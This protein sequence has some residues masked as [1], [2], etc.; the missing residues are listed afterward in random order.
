VASSTGIS[1][2][3]GASDRFKFQREKPPDPNTKKSSFRSY[4]SAYFVS[5]T[6][7]ILLPY[8]KQVL[9]PFGEYLPLSHIITWPRWLVPEFMESI[10]GE[11]IAIFTLPDESRISPIIC[12]ENL[13]PELVRKAVLKGSE[14][15]VHMSNDNWFGNT[16]ASCQHNMASVIRAVENRTPVIISSNTGPSQI[17][18]GNGRIIACAHELFSQAI[19]IGTVNKGEAIQT[20]FY[21]RFG[22]LFAWGCIL[23]CLVLAGGTYIARISHKD[24]GERP[25]STM[26]NL[27]LKLRLLPDRHGK[28]QISR[29]QEVCPWLTSS[30]GK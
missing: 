13:F 25:E 26:A 29:G 15:I 22:D 16:A 27:C 30:D 21:T 11:L 24:R 1:L 18:D 28:R 14:V 8:H 2:L 12:W 3:T 20:T 10:P 6:G 7:E 5:S 19:I 9:V 23:V 4:N 17:I